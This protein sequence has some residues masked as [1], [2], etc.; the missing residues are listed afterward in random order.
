MSVVF[1]ARY[2]LKALAH[3]TIFFITLTVPHG[4][5]DLSS[6]LFPSHVGCECEFESLYVYLLVVGLYISPFFL[7]GSPPETTPPLSNTIAQHRPLQ[8]QPTPA[9]YSPLAPLPQP[10]WL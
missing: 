5:R 1:E 9:Q 2:A 8:V 6:G 7:E 10:A 4:F 3:S